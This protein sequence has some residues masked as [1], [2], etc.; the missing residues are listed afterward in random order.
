MG[1]EF[2]IFRHLE[3]LKTEFFIVL[4]RKWYPYAV[5]SVFMFIT[6][7]EYKILRMDNRAQMPKCIKIK[8]KLIKF[9]PKYTENLKIISLIWAQPE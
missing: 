8:P 6:F 4:W 5:L 3:G 7:L 1:T 2:S 9:R